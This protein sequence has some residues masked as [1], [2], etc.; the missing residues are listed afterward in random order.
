MLIYGLYEVFV[1]ITKAN[2]CGFA[3]GRSY[4]NA[5][6]PAVRRIVEHRAAGIVKRR[7]ALRD[8]SYLRVSRVCHGNVRYIVF[9]SLGVADELQPAEII[10]LIC[11]L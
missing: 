8:H 7:V 2:S 11:E 3:L 1:C 5:V 9:V 4:G 6:L 10:E